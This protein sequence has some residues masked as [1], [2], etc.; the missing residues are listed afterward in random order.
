MRG[1]RGLC[2]VSVRNV[3]RLNCASYERQFVLG[4]CLGRVF[5]VGLRSRLLESCANIDGNYFGVDDCGVRR[6]LYQRETD[7]I[8][9]LKRRNY[10][11]RD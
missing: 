11:K 2:R 4:D 1:D 3:E 10:G 8:T 7:K 5:P 6:G 9:Y